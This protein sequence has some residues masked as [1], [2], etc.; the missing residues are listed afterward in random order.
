ME[1]NQTLLLTNM[2]E[3]IHD[4][5]KQALHKTHQ[6]LEKKTKSYRHKEKVLANV[7]TKLLDVTNDLLD[8][9]RLKSKKVE[10]VNEEFNIN[11]VLNELS[12]SICTQFSGS[13]I[14]L[15]FDIDKNVPRH[16]IGRFIA[17]GTNA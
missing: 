7:E 5:A 9:L 15:I 12:G 2:S 1:K 14:E 10:I 4:M 17:F 8:F 13:E 6:A 16:L 11:N 3:N